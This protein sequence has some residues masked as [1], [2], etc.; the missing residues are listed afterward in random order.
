MNDLNEIKK[1]TEAIE[2]LNKALVSYQE[3][4]KKSGNAEIPGLDKLKQ[5]I[6]V[7]DTLKS[8]TTD[9]K[10][11]GRGKMFPLSHY[12]FENADNSMCSLGY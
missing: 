10:N 2:E 7:M 1:N 3:T 11:V 6:L 8:I 4:L 12:C 9:F 5:I